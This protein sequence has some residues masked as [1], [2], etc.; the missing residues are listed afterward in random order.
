MRHRKGIKKLGK[1]TDQR[2]ALLKSL[3][4]ALFTYNKIE[5][6]DTRAKEVKR[7]VEKLITCAKSNALPNKRKVQALV[8]D[9]ELVKKIF[10]DYGKKF[11]KRNGGYTRIIKKG[12]RKGDG[13]LV[14]VLEFVS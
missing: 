1:P 4:K 7:F 10:N 5:T 6:T 3:A 9:R 12:Y 8:Q 13:A 11:E 14:S 2:L